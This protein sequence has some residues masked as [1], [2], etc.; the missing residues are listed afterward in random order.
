[1]QMPRLNSITE[2][3]V[4]TCRREPLDRTLIW[5]QRHLSHALRAFEDRYNTHRPH[6][7]IANTR[8]L[9]PLS[10][11]I[12]DPGMIAHLDIRRR[13]RLGGILHEYQHVV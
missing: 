7:A 1:M 4:R 6:Q 8:P 13:E 5:N 10:A 12:T 3:W 11:P 2:R 9:H